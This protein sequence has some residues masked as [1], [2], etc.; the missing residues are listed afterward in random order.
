[1][2]ASDSCGSEYQRGRRHAVQLPSSNGSRA[3]LRAAI[4]SGTLCVVACGDPS[5]RIDIRFDSDTLGARAQ[6]LAVY[7]VDSCEGLETATTPPGV[8]QRRIEAR[9]GMRSPA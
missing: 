1:M 2:A 7:L 6:T 3:S 9:R 8:F 4:V 5:Y